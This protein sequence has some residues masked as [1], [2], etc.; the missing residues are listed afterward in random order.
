MNLLKFVSKCIYPSS[1]VSGQASLISMVSA[2]CA[3]AMVHR[4]DFFRLYQKDKSS[5]VKVN[6]RQ[7]SSSCRRVPEAAELAYA[8]K[9]KESIISQKLGSGTFGKLPIVFST[10]VNLLCPLYSTARRCCLQRLKKQNC[11]AENFSKNSNLDDSGISVPVFPSRTNL[12]N[13]QD[14]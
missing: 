9:T 1:K 8:N 2:A 3:A 6:F 13:S 11:F 4:N 10:K 5:D 12:Y 14:G 7:A